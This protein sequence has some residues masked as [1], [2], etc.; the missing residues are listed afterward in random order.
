MRYDVAVVGLGGMGSAILA[1]CAGRGSAV[2]LEQFERGHQF[3]SSGGKSRLIRKAYFEDPAY[4][5]LLLRAYELWRALEERTGQALLQITGLLLV[6]GEDSEIIQGAQRAA[7][8]HQ[9]PLEVLDT[10]EL[11]A[12]YPLLRVVADEVGVFETDG[13]VLNPERA[14][15]AHLQVAEKAGA[16]MRFGLEML[17]WEAT[18]NGFVVRCADQTVV[19]SRRVVLSLGAWFKEMLETLGLPIRVQRNIQA[20]FKPRSE[21]LAAGRFP[22]FMVDRP[23]LPAPLYGFPD[24]GD[25]LKAAFH[26]HGGLTDAAHLDREI[27]LTRDIDP[28]WG[29]LEQCM[30]GAIS[31]FLEAK[32]CPYALTPDAHFIVDLHPTNP[33]VVLSGGFSG[34]GFKFAPVIGE[35]CADL[36]FE[37]KSRHDIDFLSLRRFR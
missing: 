19:Q 23:G 10:A 17:G 29:G 9:L 31:H 18:D 22:P 32:V 34:H 3:G 30:P 37:R 11:R 16:E 7:R 24:F 15:E 26:A 13:G 28:I 1:H 25:G 14:T 5:P 35:I 27:D 4:V 36:V 12:R 21:A 20:W 2:G 8:E 6:G 33:G